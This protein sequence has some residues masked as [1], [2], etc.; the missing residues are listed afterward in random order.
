M[1]DMPMPVVA[2]N[3]VFSTIWAWNRCSAIANH[4]NV[5]SRSQIPILSE[6]KIA[7]RRT[8]LVF[9]SFLFLSLFPFCF[10]NRIKLRIEKYVQQ[11]QKKNE[12]EISSKRRLRI[13]WIAT[14][15]IIIQWCKGKNMREIPN[16]KWAFCCFCIFF[17]IIS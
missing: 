2:Y 13:G 4:Q 12:Q 9:S 7:D 16:M 11:Q 17:R 3:S 1:Y 10:L 15:T 14:T 6:F 8:F 5:C